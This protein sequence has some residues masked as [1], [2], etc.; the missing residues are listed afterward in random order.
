MERLAIIAA[1]TS[2]L[3]NNL[4]FWIGSLWGDPLLLLCSMNAKDASSVLMSKT[5]V[6]AAAFSVL[7]AIVLLGAGIWT[8]QVNRRGL[9]NLVAVFA[10]VHFRHNGSSACARVFRPW[11]TAS[12]HRVCAD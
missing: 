4:G 12:R 5:A 8:M 7:W 9:I 1:R 3:L 2:L 11:R 10:G 6:P